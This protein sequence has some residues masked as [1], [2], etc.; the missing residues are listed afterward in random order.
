MIQDVYEPLEKYQNEFREAFAR[1]A[2]LEFER[3]VRASGVDAAA[4]AETNRQLRNRHEELES[5]RS[6]RSNWRLLGGLTWLMIL[7]GIAAVVWPFIPEDLFSPDFWHDFVEPLKPYWYLVSGGGA[8]VAYL[9]F[10]FYLRIVLRNLRSLREKISRLEKE[11]E[12]LQ[13]EAWHLLLAVPPR[14]HFPVEILLPDSGLELLL[15]SGKSTVTAY[16]NTGKR[17]RTKTKAQ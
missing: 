1:N 2:S 6:S 11:I 5:S 9:T 4:N 16:R 3:L 17:C 13:Q 12:Q 7:A 10:I 8:A 14:R 15:C